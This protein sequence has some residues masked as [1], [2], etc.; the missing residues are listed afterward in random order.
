MGIAEKIANAERTDWPVDRMS[1]AEA[2]TVIELAKIAAQIS[3][4]RAEKGLTKAEFARYM[5]V[6]PRTV[7]KWENGECDIS[8]GTLYR[9]CGKLGLKVSISINAPH[10]KSGTAEPNVC[11]D[12]AA[13][14]GAAGRKGG[15]DEKYVS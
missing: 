3:M 8:I 2:G 12:P 4:W 9:I 13:A 15:T 5:G 6:S 11:G 10:T 14:A 1:D 7:S